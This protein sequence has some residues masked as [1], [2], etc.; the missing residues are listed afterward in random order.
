V[1][2]FG[3][4]EYFSRMLVRSPALLE[5]LMDARRDIGLGSA[6]FLERGLNGALGTATTIT[7]KLDAL[8]RFKHREEL[9]IGM[10]DLMG[11][12]PLP[13]ICR[14]LSR[15]ADACLAAALDLAAHETAKRC[16]MDGSCGGIAVIGAGK[17]GGRELIYGS[18]LDILFVYD[19]A[20]AAA[21][22]PGMTVFEYFSKMAE[23]MISYLTTMTREGFAYRVDTRLRPTG[24]K[25]PLAQSVEAFRNHYATQAETWERQSLVN[26]RFVAG[27]RKVGETF[28]AA[29]RGLIFREEEPA[30][31]AADVRNMRKRMQDERGKEDASQYNIK[32]GTGGLVDIEFLAQYLQLRHGKVHASLQVPGTVNALRALRKERLLLPED[33][34]A[35]RAAY[36]FLRRLESRMRIVANQSTSFLSRDPDKL[37]ILAKRL[38]YGEEI[39]P[40]GKQLLAEYE[41]TRTEVRAL[42][43]RI[44]AG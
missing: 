27:D 7:D 21:P 36:I 11:D 33:H 28:S 39:G 14:S 10:A 6:A 42:F 20:R 5:D 2:V 40:A 8:R 3:N 44:S 4:S 37:T 13:A 34:A 26:S 15:L 23:K 29:L 25:G 31:L 18:D 16:G 1:S 22:P 30:A 43:E 32:Q 41:R 17:L 12:I 19:E 24:S 35:L 9:R 38:G